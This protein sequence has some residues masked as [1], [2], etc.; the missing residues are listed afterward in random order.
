[1]LEVMIAIILLSIGFIGMAGLQAKVTVAQAESYQRIQAL[2]LAQDMADRLIANKANAANYVGDDYGVGSGAPC[3]GPPGYQFDLCRWSEA[4][5]GT[6]ERSGSGYA[7][8]LL[9]GRGCIITPVAN[10]YH[11][12]V[13][14]Q[15]L[16]PTVSPGVSCGRDDYG[17][18]TYRRAVVLPIQLATLAGA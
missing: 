3:G 10:Q 16:V 15:G 5:R 11:V 2:L 9:D 14:W 18:D 13:V 12:I 7:G 17:S 6:S 4:I 1:M 8:T